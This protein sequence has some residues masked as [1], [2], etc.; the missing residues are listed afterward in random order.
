MFYSCCVFFFARMTTKLVADNTKAFLRA[1]KL[2]YKLGEQEDSLKYV[3][4]T[5]THVLFFYRNLYN[6]SGKSG[7][8]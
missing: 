2:Y 7:N 4:E 3:L 6:C 5:H 1:S 8:V